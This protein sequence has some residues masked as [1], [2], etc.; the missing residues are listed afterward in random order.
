MDHFKW[1]KT[2]NCRRFI[3]RTYTLNYPIN[4]Q[5]ISTLKDHGDLEIL[6]LSDYSTSFNDIF[7][8]RVEELIEISGS[9]RDV[10]LQLTIKKTAADI[11]KVIEA[12]MN[13]WSERMIKR[14]EMA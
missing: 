14:N 7:K 1:V 6:C 8:I 13:S 5:L 3:K 12:E 4:D 9:F 2:R 11:I 10:Y